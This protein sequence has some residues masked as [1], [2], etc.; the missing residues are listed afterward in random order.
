MW[1]D[2]ELC[3]SSVDMQESN[4]TYSVIMK[5]PF[6]CW[7]FPHAGAETIPQSKKILKQRQN[8]LKEIFSE[9]L[10]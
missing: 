5:D 10:V 7:A 4:N 2:T 9:G 3:E 8:F 6:N 1:H